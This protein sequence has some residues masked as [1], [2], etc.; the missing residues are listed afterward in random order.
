[1]RLGLPW[2]PL[3]A[4]RTSDGFD[5]LGTQQSATELSALHQRVVRPARKSARSSL[6]EADALRRSSALGH[7]PKV[8][9]LLAGWLCQT[10]CR[11]GM[12]CRV[13]YALW[14]RYNPAQD[15]VADTTFDPEGR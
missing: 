15:L 6:L 14:R 8:A 10:G 13:V 7:V 5:V 4:F 1:V 12:L 2:Q 9:A 11:V 3:T